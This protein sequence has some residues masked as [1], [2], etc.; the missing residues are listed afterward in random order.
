MMLF[1]TL[2]IGCAQTEKT[3]CDELCDQLYQTC[4]YDAYPSYESCQQGC[5]YSQ[6]EGADV[7]G[8]LSCVTKAG[9]DTFAIL[10]CE[11]KFGAAES[12]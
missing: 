1:F 7:E 4:E 12:E 3:T 2:L 8:E 6:S 9:C 5:A 10:E 11:H